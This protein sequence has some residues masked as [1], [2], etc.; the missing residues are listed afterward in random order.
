MADSKGI[1]YAAGA[2]AVLALYA[3]L[4]DKSVGTLLQYLLKGQG[5][6]LVPRD[7]SLAITSDSS[8]TSTSSTSTS[9]SGPTSSSANETLGQQLAAAYGWSS[10]QEW[11]SLAD[12][13]QRES[14]W[15]N[16]AQ[17]PDSTAYG[18]AQFLDTT[19]SDVGCTKT[20][21]ATQQINCGLA[22][23][24]KSYGNPIVAWAHEQQ[25]GW[26]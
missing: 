9:S 25:F 8:L 11:T 19:W 16:T 18:I 24:Q 22:Y 6:N 21:N 23:I 26:Y 4:S 12:L 5:P 2:A 1:Y 10:G 13:W 7:S 14:G 3:G 17:N 20:S 15:S